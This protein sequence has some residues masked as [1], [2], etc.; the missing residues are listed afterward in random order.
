MTKIRE[1]SYAVFKHWILLMSGIA[2]L[3]LALL[4]RFRHGIGLPD[5]VFLLV[6]AACFFVAFHFAWLDK[7]K[8]LQ[9]T[10]GSAPE[11]VL[12][13]ECSKGNPLILRNTAL[14]RTTYRSKKSLSAT[15]A[16]PNST[17]CL[18]SLR[19]PTSEFYLSSVT[20]S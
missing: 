1:H 11:V 18:T 9:A 4:E 12:E 16:Q 5:W 15:A 6:S 3:A 2:S 14:P 20:S 10:L 13:W 8:E 19:E 17:R 7:D